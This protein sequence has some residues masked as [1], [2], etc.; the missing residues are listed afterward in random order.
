MTAVVRLIL[1]SLVV[2]ILL[3]S[4]IAVA[5]T[6]AEDATELDRWHG[7]LD[8]VKETLEQDVIRR[9]LFGELLDKVNLLRPEIEALRAKYLPLAE[10]QK[11]LLEALATDGEVEESVQEDAKLVEERERQEQILADLEATAKRALVLVQT[12]D[13]LLARIYSR[14]RNQFANSLLEREQ[15][16]LNPALWQISLSGFSIFVDVANRTIT[17]WITVLVQTGGGIISAI[18]MSL[19]LVGLFAP[20]VLE[21]LL[22]RPLV[23]WLVPSDELAAQRLRQALL[24]ALTVAISVGLVGLMLALISYFSELD[25]ILPTRAKQ[26]Q[27]SAISALMLLVFF[28]SISLALL[29]GGDRTG[30]FLA[31]DNKTALRLMGIILVGAGVMSVSLLLERYTAIFFAPLTVFVWITGLSSVVI[32]LLGLR[33]AR[34]LFTPA[35]AHAR[36]EN[37]G[38]TWAWWTSL[39]FAASAVCVIAPIFGFHAF[40]GFL[41][42][43]IFWFAGAIAVLAVL[44]QLIDQGFSHLFTSEHGMHRYLSKN[45]RGSRRL[46]QVAVVFA[47]ILKALI[48]IVIA[49]QIAAS[50]GVESGSQTL[51]DVLRRSITG[52][53]IG[54]YTIS[55]GSIG[56]VALVLIGGVWLTRSVQAWL[57][58]RFLPN[59]DLDIGVRNSVKTGI[60]YLGIGLA[61]ILAFSFAGFS[62]DRFAIVAGALSVGI[63]FGL[64][65]IVNN[66]V[67]GL[68]LLAERPI[69]AGDWISVNG[70]E[71]TV[72]QINVRSTEVQTFDRAV[73]IIPNSDLISGTLRNNIIRDRSGRI[74][75]AI[76]VGYGSDARQVEELLLTCAT[77]HVN[78]TDFPKP[79]VVFTDFGDHALL[80]ELRCYLPDISLGLTTRSD[81]RFDILK[82]FRDA[83]IEIPYPQLDVHLDKSD[84]TNA[85][86]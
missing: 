68:I 1:S 16:I 61:I 63:G 36:T 78:V 18:V 79:Y 71:G 80:F 21:R 82:K 58:N 28:W 22:I 38:Q 81:L 44:N 2:P 33:L 9:V 47:G 50:W 49:L 5:Q 77:E 19:I 73:V 26:A 46:S 30:R 72:S 83:D 67:S 8:Q 14:Q 51:W 25:N 15:S 31:V 59:T 66:F 29:R 60:G 53:E 12:A 27:L 23:N 57:E 7:E 43:Q 86:G 48:F 62:L 37:G 41:R 39:L 54:G 69:R 65:S 20:S 17:T 42:E 84:E 4:A 74:I 52:Y 32:G 3:W 76:G 34:L 85:E 35:V 40:A 10:Q 13:N 56:L 6:T 64:Q 24:A 75:V 70:I 55:L 45:T 11:V